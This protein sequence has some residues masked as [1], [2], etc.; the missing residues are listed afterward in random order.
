MIYDLD[1]ESPIYRLIRVNGRVTF[2]NDMKNVTLHAKHI[3]VRAGELHIGNKTHPFLGLCTIMLHG[4]KDAKHIVYDNAIEAGNKLIANLNIMRIYGKQRSH[5]FSRLFL[6]AKK[7]DKTITIAK[8]MDLVA[9]DRLAL[10]P[11]SYDN[12]A[13]DD[14]FVT[15]YDTLTGLTTLDRELDYYHWGNPVSKSE[16]YNGADMRGEVLLLTRNIVIKGEDIESWG[17]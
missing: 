4:E 15:A 10:L 11:T 6:E 5:H 17:G 14:V 2:K 16:N 9:G 12:M 8:G 1:E 3:F 7:G 13:S